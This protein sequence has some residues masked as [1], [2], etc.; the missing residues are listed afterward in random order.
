M[1]TRGEDS[2]PLLL[3]TI[4]QCCLSKPE[5]QDTLEGWVQWWLMEHEI[6]WAVTEIKKALEELV[7]RNLMIGRAGADGRVHYR[8]NQQRLE[9]IRKTLA[10]ERHA[11]NIVSG[12]KQKPF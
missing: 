9:Y 12:K 6:S 2:E 11:P 7:K 8:V 10:K 5:R 3:R 1:K 4:L